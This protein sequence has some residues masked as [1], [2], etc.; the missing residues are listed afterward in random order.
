MWS[1]THLAGESW[2]SHTKRSL[3]LSLLLILAGNAMVLHAL[4]PFW[5]QP[6]WL[7]AEHVADQICKE[8][9]TLKE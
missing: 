5:Q 1:W 2:L 8:M 7:C 6:S 9:S 3:K 4:I